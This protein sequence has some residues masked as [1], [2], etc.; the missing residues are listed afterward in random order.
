MRMIV[1]NLEIFKISISLIFYTAYFSND[2]SKITDFLS[3]FFDH[4]YKINVNYLVN[5]I[6][7]TSTENEKNYNYSEVIIESIKNRSDNK[8]IDKIYTF[9]KLANTIKMTSDDNSKFKSLFEAEPKIA[10]SNNDANSEISLTPSLQSQESG[11]T[12]KETIIRNECINKNPIFLPTKAKNDI[13]LYGN[14]N[15]FV[16]VRYIFCIYERLNKV[17]SY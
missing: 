14:E 13:L 3:M 7:T 5:S 4:F 1:D 6:N 15:C 16:L 2:V 8:E 12:Y 11:R 9:D 17:Y 10:S